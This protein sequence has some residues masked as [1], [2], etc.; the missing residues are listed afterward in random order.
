MVINQ[1]QPSVNGQDAADLSKYTIP[2]F[3]WNTEDKV[4]HPDIVES[5]VWEGQFESN[6]MELTTKSQREEK[7]KI[8]EAYK[9]PRT[10]WAFSVVSKPGKV[11]STRSSPVTWDDF[12]TLAA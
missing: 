6:T 10:K 9:F 5:V 3:I 2:F 8:N 7:I 11:T 1:L 12:Q 4:C